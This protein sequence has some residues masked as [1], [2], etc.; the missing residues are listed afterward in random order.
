MKLASTNKT[1]AGHDPATETIFLSQRHASFL[2]KMSD[3]INPAMPKA[4]GWPHAIR[5]ILDRIE[6]SNIDLTVASS[7]YDVDD[8]LV[9]YIRR[10]SRLLRDF[11]YALVCLRTL[12]K[13]GGKEA[14]SFLEHIISL[15]KITRE[16]NQLARQL[17]TVT[18]RTG[19]RHLCEWYLAE[20]ARITSRLPDHMRMFE[21]TL[22]AGLLH[23]DLESSE[24]EDPYKTLFAAAL[25]AGHL[26]FGPSDILAVTRLNRD[27]GEELVSTVLRHLWL[28]SAEKWPAEPPWTLIDPMDE[29]VHEMNRTVT[30]YCLVNSLGKVMLEPEGD[31]KSILIL[32]EPQPA[33]GPLAKKAGA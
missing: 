17:R 6:E 29:I 13:R 7:E 5:T 23:W 20:G 4:F 22:R 1:V 3:E 9:D 31:L 10:S 19:Y 28:A 16:T 18:L 2:A 12:G 27:V 26:R 25:H 21:E 30:T 33:S 11:K 32:Y 15:L 8:D 14:V 24:T